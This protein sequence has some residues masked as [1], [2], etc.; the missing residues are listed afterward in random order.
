MKKNIYFSF[1]LTLIIFAG[2]AKK[3]QDTP[4][5]TKDALAQ[6][7]SGTITGVVEESMNSGGYTYMRLKNDG[8]DIWV[9]A[10]T[11]S[12]S[13]GDKVTFKDEL[14]MENF[15]ST[16]L[17]RTFES[18]YF[19]N[20]LTTG[21]TIGNMMKN[22]TSMAN[23]QQGVQEPIKNTV[24]GL[25]PLEDG[26][27]IADIYRD[28]IS[29]NGES[30][31]VRGKVVKFSP[32]IMNTNWIHIQDG[33]AHEGLYDLTVTTNKNVKIGDQI[34]VSGKVVLDKDFGYGYLYEVLVENADIDVE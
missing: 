22:P 10:S 29:L 13:V 7:A 31:K 20:D 6:A 9:A 28:K 33:T 2:C 25:K 26:S 12:I 4:Y 19:A 24:A 34:I 15:K 14:P 30:V 1:L 23:R 3:N 32:Q 17:D 8:K 11:M 27:T 16:S 5:Q 21:T 18:I